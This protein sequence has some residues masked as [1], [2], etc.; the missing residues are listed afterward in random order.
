MNDID[1]LIATA[2]T[3]AIVVTTLLAAHPEM[4]ILVPMS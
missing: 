2:A 3:V 4:L 1:A